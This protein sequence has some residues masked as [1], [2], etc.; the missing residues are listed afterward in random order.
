MPFDPQSSRTPI[1]S[2]YNEPEILRALVEHGAD[3]DRIQ[4]D[5]VPAIVGLIGTRQWESALY[6]IEKGADLD[7]STTHGLSVDY[8]LNDWK[9]SVFG[10]H[11]LGWDTVR[12]AIAKRRATPNE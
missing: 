5:G 10:E 3:I 2:V 1:G 9:D 4:P 8:Y 6:L 11:P 12:E 7:V